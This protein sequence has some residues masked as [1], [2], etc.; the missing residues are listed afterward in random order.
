[1]TQSRVPSLC[2]VF[3]LGVLILSQADAVLAQEREAFSPV[4]IDFFENKV[5][6]LLVAHCLECHGAKDDKLRG[7]LRLTSRQEIIEGGD[8]GA[9]VIAGDPDNSL[10]MSAVHY[11]EFEMPPSGQLPDKEI[12][13]LAEWIRIGLPDPRQPDLVDASEMFDMAAARKHWAFQP[14]QDE[15]G[16]YSAAQLTRVIDQLVEERLNRDNEGKFQ[17]K[18]NGPADRETLLRRLH[19][20]LVGLPPTIEEIDSFTTV[21]QRVDELLASPRYG[22]RWG[23]HWLDVAR[24]AESSGGGR[25]LMF[26]DAWR[27]RDY[28]IDA[29]NKDKPV[30]QFVKEQIAGDLLPAESREQRNEQIVAT[31]FLALGP[32]NYEQQDKEGLAIDVVDEQID[33]VGRAF[34]GMTLGC[35]RCHDH[36]FDPITTEDYY[37]LAGI[38][39]STDTVVH[40]NVSKYVETSIASLEQQQQQKQY[41]QTVK[42]LTSQLTKAKAAVE[43][44]G[45]QI[46]GTANAKKSRP[47]SGLPGLVIDNLAAE[48]IGQWQESE[49]AGTFID[50][51][52]IHDQDGGK[53]TKKVIFTPR[54]KIGGEYE[55]RM[56]YTA[57][58]NRASNVP[59]LIDHQDGQTRQ[60]VNQS[61]KP[62]IGGLFISLGRYRF[63][64][65]NIARVTIE[66]EGTDG[67]VIVDAIQFLP[68]SPDAIPDPQQREK[69][70][71]STVSDESSE[72]ELDQEIKSALDHYQQIDKRLKTLKAKPPKAGPV[73]MSV[74]DGG[75][76]AD[77]PIHIRGAFRNLGAIVPRG[78]VQVCTPLLR[79]T[80][81]TNG[82][83]VTDRPSPSTNWEI[84]PDQSGRRQLA[85]W[86]VH[87][88]HPLTARVYVNRVWRYLFGN[89]LVETPDNFGLM[90]ASPS[91]PELLD[92]LADQFVENGWSTK[93]LI[94]QIM[95]TRTFQQH[96]GSKLLTGEGCESATQIIEADDRN[97]L[98]WRFN[99]QRLD[100]EVLR[101][102]ILAVSGQL[103]LTAGGLTIRKITKYDSDYT[104]DTRRRSVYV[105]F[106]RNSMLDI[107][108]VFD[109]AN[110]N[111]VTGHRVTSTL[112]TQSL[113]LMNSPMVIQSARVMAGNVLGMELA[114]HPD[115]ART[116][117]IT[118]IY[119]NLL[120][121]FPSSDEVATSL[122]FL[123]DFEPDA[124]SET[125]EQDAWQNLIHAL[126]CSLEFRYMN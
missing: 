37:A 55:V 81:P 125:P 91:H 116:E 84:P 7:G 101:D 4:Q 11:D 70:D 61:K 82:V 118:L 112:P 80:Q 106:F 97:R 98:L 64:A 90:G 78:F 34:M 50:A 114:D 100:A 27:Y 40:S 65:D 121:R 103:D 87:P 51:N 110:P 13:V 5:R 48:R 96:I 49:F 44:L 108:E 54:F 74:R 9:A 111:L 122:S 73:T 20:T 25:S 28:V 120:G 119:R 95:A 77:S 109:V 83:E 124:K 39:K 126:F 115:G 12:E 113:F 31:G 45:G 1:M 6:P 16:P 56:S 60:R 99:R 86:L 62:P 69:P 41:R 57:G 67:H 8:S 102:S 43:S 10:L 53:G 52:Y 92:Y 47:A 42:R 123:D 29:F 36:K 15:Q 59:I 3:W 30:D 75:K 79:E 85:E 26:S 58:G 46:P 89:G 66:T 23:R 93:W 32:T 63:E 104:F 107:F 19:L 38:F 76:P 71:D 88:D 17:L 117:R 14:R 68:L 21:K 24:F 105:P 2:M 22:E 94:R 35:A 72:A 18:M 33:T